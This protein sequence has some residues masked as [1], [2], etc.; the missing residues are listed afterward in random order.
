[1]VSNFTFRNCVHHAVTGTVHL[2]SS[3]MPKNVLERYGKPKYGFLYPGTCKLIHVSDQYPE[4]VN[5]AIWPVFTSGDLL[6]P[7][8]W[9]ADHLDWDLGTTFESVHRVVRVT[10]NGTTFRSVEVRFELTVHYT[11]P[12]ENQADL[13]DQLLSQDS[14]VTFAL[15]HAPDKRLRPGQDGWYLWDSSPIELSTLIRLLENR[16]HSID[17]DAL[18]HMVWEQHTTADWSK[19]ASAAYKNVSL[20]SGSNGIAYGLD[21]LG[22]YYQVEKFVSGM[23]SSDPLTAV[24]NTYLGVHYGWKLTLADTKELLK[25]FNSQFSFKN[26]KLC[27]ARAD[28]MFY[29]VY[30]NPN[31]VIESVMRQILQKL[32][33]ALDSSIIWDLTPYSFVVDWI[34]PIG[35]YLTQMDSYYTV[36]TEYDPACVIQTVESESSYKDDMLQVYDADLSLTS[37]IRLVSTSLVQPSFEE[38]FQPE[39]ALSHMVEAG[40]LVISNLSSSAKLAKRWQAIKNQLFSSKV[41]STTY[42]TLGSYYHNK[43]LKKTSLK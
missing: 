26:W 23:L 33:L 11:D 22:M 12:E 6:S 38:S 14:K 36:A 27:Q 16:Q 17:V 42:G 20:N 31:K 37:Y 39:G 28:G 3:Q 40:A 19:L 7:I 32:D 13:F 25:T 2:A 21:Y 9:R 1:K 41:P 34:L 18:T 43:G 35:D 4:R 8:I 15:D 10:N 30:S 29:T 5:S 24:A